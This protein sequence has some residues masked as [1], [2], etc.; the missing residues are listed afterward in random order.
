[1]SF[2]ELGYQNMSAEKTPLLVVVVSSTGDGD[3]PDNATAFYMS[4]RK[5]H[6]A[7]ALSGVQYTVLGL[8]D[9]NYTR[10]MHVPRVVRNRW[11]AVVWAGASCLCSAIPASLLPL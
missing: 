5:Q 7:G 2:N 4:L 6:E 11:G 3:P 8:G 10:F 1:M 9:S